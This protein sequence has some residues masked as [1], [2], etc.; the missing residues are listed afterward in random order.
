MKNKLAS[1]KLIKAGPHT[2]LQDCGRLG[3]KHI[4][5]GQS[6]AADK[7]AYYWANRLLNN[8]L[9]APVLECMMGPMSIQFEASTR[10][11]VCGAANKITLND[12]P[13]NG[14]TTIDILANDI[15]TVSPAKYGVYSYIA[16]QGGF[17]SHKVLGS[18]S[19]AVR[20]QIGPNKGQV[21]AKGLELHYAP[22]I[23]NSTE[24][25]KSCPW[26]HVPSYETELKLRFIPSAQ[27]QFFDAKKIENLGTQVFTI[28]N[29]SNKMGTRLEYAKPE[30][31]KLV[32]QGPPNMS[33]AVNLGTIQIPASGE[34]IVLLADHQTIGGYPK[35]GS[36]YAGDCYA[37]AQ[38]RAGQKVRLIKGS[39]EEAQEDLRKFVSTF[40]RT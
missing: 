11:C 17:A 37:L 36:V 23:R 22:Y 39:L 16:I 26:Y 2:T 35:L 28:S 9:N 14:W 32:Y 33:Q 3:W 34:P 10:V 21:L 7:H 40:E 1:A 30:S 13:V 25:N 24:L 4:G 8:S 15:L 6:G 18:Y 20:D 12:E 19:T 27:F 31:E 5:V 38:R 29:N